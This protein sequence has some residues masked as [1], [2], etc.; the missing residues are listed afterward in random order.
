MTKRTNKTT[1]ATAAAA[2]FAGVDLSHLTGSRATVAAHA[3]KVAASETPAGELIRAAC[4]ERGPAA[5]MGMARNPLQKVPRIA[6]ALAAG[7]AY[8]SAEGM[9]DS[10]K[11]KED[12]SVPVALREL[13]AGNA[14][15]KALAAAALGRYPGGANA[16]I[17]AALEALAFF[18]VV[19]RKSAGGRNA[20]YAIASGADA[21][22][23]ALM[24]A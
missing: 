22:A 3:F 7:V 21:R 13:G 20:E 17:P 18:G 15:Q 6:A 9:A 4:G 14:R 1:A 24:P 5:L 8:C 10:G 19:E 23:A 11:G 2:D 12:A 16:Q